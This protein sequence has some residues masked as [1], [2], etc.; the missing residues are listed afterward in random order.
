MADQYITFDRDALRRLPKVEL[1]VHLEGT[2][3]VDRIVAIAEELGEPLPR[4]IADLFSFDD[5]SEF[6]GFLDWT[7]ALIRTP[8]IAADVAHDFA[9]RAARNGTLYAEVI[10]NPTHWKGW[11]LGELVE[12][13]TVGFERA[14]SEGL[15]E[16]HLL[17][18]ILRS[19][20]SDE[21]VELVTWMGECR[22]RRVV[23]LSIDGDEARAGRTGSRFAEAFALAGKFGFGRTAH[24]GESSDSE[25]VRDAIFQLCVDRIDHGTR[26]VDDADL[27]QILAGRKIALNVCPTS[28]LVHLYPDL[29]SHPF[30]RLFAADV[31]MTINTDDPGYL[32]TE[33]V[34]EFTKVAGLMNWGLPD[35]AA[36]TRIAI[37]ASF[38]PAS[39]KAVL[40]AAVDSYLA[41]LDQ[42]DRT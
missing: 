28:N 25:G 10:I 8:Q 11:D 9:I 22:P 39:T 41:A 30:P 6:L 21:A 34:D 33:L 7:C 32:D 27:V 40:H 15:T 16:C 20:S 18:S 2:F 35:L 38:A 17:L 26:A 19:Q 24:A 4:P 1:H 5:L 23:G 42:E 14:Q 12:A 37:D 29:A 13:L 36:V 31:A 3:S